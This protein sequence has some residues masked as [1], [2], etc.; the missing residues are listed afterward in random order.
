MNSSLETSTQLP[1]D[2]IKS[3]VT[4]LVNKTLDEIKN[5]FVDESFEFNYTKRVLVP[6]AVI[7]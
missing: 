6:K 4:A 1:Y 2:K 5:S 3:M 7:S